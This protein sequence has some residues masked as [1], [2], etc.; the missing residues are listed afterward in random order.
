M[1]NF[2]RWLLTKSITTRVAGKKADSSKSFREA[3][4]SS[5]RHN[6]FEKEPVSKTYKNCPNCSAQVQLAALLC[7]ACDYNFIAMPIFRN[8]LLNPPTASRA[9]D[10]G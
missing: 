5:R 3:G 4:P 8:K 7:D 1:K 6:F 9:A 10:R 2:L